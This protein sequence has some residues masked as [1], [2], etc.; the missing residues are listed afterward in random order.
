MYNK[1]LLEIQLELNQ[2]ETTTERNSTDIFE[3]LGDIGGLEYILA[4]VI[5]VLSSYFSAKF[6]NLGVA[7]TLYVAKKSKKEI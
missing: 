6:L 7:Q 4:M 5:E 3:W 1:I 2:Y